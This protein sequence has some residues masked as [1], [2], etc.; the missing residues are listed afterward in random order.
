MFERF[1]IISKFSKFLVPLTND[2]NI[3]SHNAFRYILMT[4][5]L[6]KTTD[7]VYSIEDSK[8]FCYLKISILLA[9]NRP[10]VYIV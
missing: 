9:S 4:P 1:W 2:D 8:T 10:N 3:Y 7:E 6:V 5:K